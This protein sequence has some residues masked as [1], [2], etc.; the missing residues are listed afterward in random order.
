MATVEGEKK[1]VR[2][3]A[4]LRVYNT[5]TR[6]KEPF[7]PVEPGK[8]GMYVCGPTVYM[9]SHIGHMVG[10][11]VFDTVKRYLQFKGY[12]VT[13]V[14][15]ITDVEDKLIKRAEEEGRSVEELARDVEADYMECLGA[16]GVTTVDHFP[17]ATEHIDD[18]IALVRTL[19]DK[20]YAYAVDGDVYMDTSK[21]TDY[22]K[23]SGRNVE[24][25]AAG[26]RVEVDE[27]KKNPEDFALW[28]S[29]KPG[30]P[31]WESPWGRGR[32]GWHI[33]CSVM[34][35]HYLG[36]TFDIHGGGLDLV[37]PH[38]ENEIAQ[39]ESAT[40]KPFAKYW[41]HNGLAQFA[42][43]K[44][45][46][47]LGNIVLVRDLLKEQAPET[48]RFLI[49][50]THYR[51]PI[52]FTDERLAE[53]RRALDHFYRLFER[54]EQLTGEN[55]FATDPERASEPAGAPA[56]EGEG[57]LLTQVLTDAQERFYEA[58]DDDFNTA[59]AIAEL[60]ELTSATNRYIEA[61]GLATTDDVGEADRALLLS[62][63][64]TVRRLGGL[65]GLFE[66]PVSAVRGPAPEETKLVDLLIEVRS[67]ARLA[68][69]YDLADFIRSQLSE[70]G[71]ALED[72][73]GGTVWRRST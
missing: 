64:G 51:R 20:G 50:S 67:R 17:R 4:T 21:L 46:K 49:L 3:G 35:T 48:L 14:I 18:I 43:E 32:P 19:T 33:E 63:A 34:S 55:V 54:V 6:R 45:S 29:S 24:E 42:N 40:G 62:S 12:D 30:E 72:T 38:H 23:L 1:A 58:M 7:E 71:V 47:S 10:P 26:A 27:R 15:N 5:L 36:E 44:M 11:V 73:R 69:Q 70:L 66:K 56:A 22:G 65:M 41:M 59:G 53:V 57:A 37:F 60:F 61:R 25:L 9:Y 2:E 28:K 31:A 16:L 39:S 13:F 68:K 8:V 52:H